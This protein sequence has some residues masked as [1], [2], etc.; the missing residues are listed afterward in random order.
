MSRRRLSLLS[1]LLIGV[2]AA[3]GGKA[4]KEAKGGGGPGGGGPG[5]DKPATVTAT[6]VAL[7]DFV[8]ALE[9]V[10]TAYARES[11]TLGA[12]VTE[13]IRAIRF[14]D[15]QYVRKGQILIELSQAEET[16]DL[17]Q[18]RA[19]LTEAQ[20]QLKRIEALVKDGYATRARLDELVSARDS[21]RGEVA[22]LEARVQDRFIRA[23]FA[24]VVGLRRVSAGSM[25]SSSSGIVELSDTSLIKLDF[26]V[27]ETALAKV[28]RGQPIVAIAAAYPDQKFTGRIEAIDPR[29]DMVTRAV[30]L[31][32][33]I[34]NASGRL[35]PGMLL[36]VQIEQSR[37]QAL[38]VPEQAVIAEGD[39]QFLYRV[40]A[41]GKSVEK[42]RI[43]T[44][45]R[46][47]GFIEVTGGVPAGTT[48]VVDG[49][50]KLRDGGKVNV[51]E[52]TGRN[53]TA[54]A[55]PAA[56]AVVQ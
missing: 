23:P 27:P 21:A 14:Q 47:P 26:T 15:G 29:V 49:T 32:A 12:D 17:A 22:S 30:G 16:A 28:R 11:V 19:R 24:G 56:T 10:G 18:A 45:V 31:R 44:G 34:P 7:H 50:V 13:R 42:T 25:A 53:V 36:N 5:K 9:A 6:A 33:L 48:I 43:T 20:S 8:D 38:A 1:A 51:V 41:S 52:Q 39:Q 4:D 3:C 55:A 37:R 46:E 2:L 54:N 40:D 35:K